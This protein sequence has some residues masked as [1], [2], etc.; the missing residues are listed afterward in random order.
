MQ[1]HPLRPAAPASP[2]A[3]L[4]AGRFIG[5]VFGLVFFGIGLTVIG[6]MWFASDGFGSP[7]LF[8]KLIAS[9]IALAFVAMGGTLAASSIF[10]G[11]LLARHGKLMGQ[12]NRDAQSGRAPTTA[13]TP[14]GYVCPHCGAA[15]AEKAEVSPMGDTK[16]AFCGQWFNVHGR[17]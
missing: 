16:C 1:Q 8:F 10:G 13:G 7:P 9:F 14:A 11:G 5:A 4:A 17:G 15:L 6:V 2:P 3:A 12:A